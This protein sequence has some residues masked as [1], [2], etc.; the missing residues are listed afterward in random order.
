LETTFYDTSSKHLH[1]FQTPFVN[2]ECLNGRSINVPLTTKVFL[3]VRAILKQKNDPTK[4]PIL[5]IRD[6]NIDVFQGT[7][8]PTSRANQFLDNAAFSLP[9]YANYTVL[10]SYT[11]NS[12]ITNKTY[13][14][15]ATAEA[16]NNLSTSGNVTVT[17]AAQGVVFTA[18]NSITLQPGFAAAL[19]SSFTATL[20]QFGNSITCGT[21][22]KQA[23]Q[24]SGGCYNV[25]VTPLAQ[26]PPV[27]Q[28]LANAFGSMDSTI[29]LYPVPAQES[30]V[31]TGL[32][33]FDRAVIS[34]FDQ[35]GRKVLILN[36]DDESPSLTLNVAALVNGVYF[37]EIQGDTKKYT[38]KIIIAK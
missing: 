17:A 11:A 37:L 7:M 10:P 8:D 4:A 30:I 28:G 26:V 20:D 36:K 27:A 33:G 23:F 12:T 15:A 13:S 29:N 31:V 1:I 34:I 5:Y 24:S 16:D 9:P 19:G 18:G 32:I 14:A 6:Y 35:S 2:L 25:V 21:L 3:R 22:Q 38:H